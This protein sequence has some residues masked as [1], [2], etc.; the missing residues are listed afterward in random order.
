DA[1]LDAFGVDGS[2]AGTVMFTIGTEGIAANA[3]LQW[4]RDGV[5]EVLADASVSL[6]PTVELCAT[7]LGIPACIEL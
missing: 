3:A 5:C 1:V 2:A 7:I 4:C 6:G